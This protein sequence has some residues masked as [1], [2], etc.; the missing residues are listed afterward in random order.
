MGKFSCQSNINFSLTLTV[1]DCS[2]HSPMVFS[3]LLR[4]V[5]AYLDPKNH[6][7]TNLYLKQKSRLSLYSLDYNI[8]IS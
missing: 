8:D 2:P 5:W 3:L 1:W 7:N 6:L 4:E